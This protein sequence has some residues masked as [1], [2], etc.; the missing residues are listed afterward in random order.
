MKR[1]RE[2]EEAASADPVEKFQESKPPHAEQGSSNQHQTT[3]PAASSEKESVKEER[4]KKK[5]RHRKKLE[6]TTNDIK[7]G[8]EPS[9]KEK[10][11][12]KFAHEKEKRRLR[13]IAKVQHNKIC[14]KCRKKG[15]EV[16]N[17][18]SVQSGSEAGICFRCGSDQHPLNAC[19]KPN[20]P[21]NPYPFATCYVCKETGHI[22]AQCPSNAKGVYVKGGGCRYCASVRHRAKDCDAK[23]KNKGGLPEEENVAVVEEG[24]GGDDL[25]DDPVYT[26]PAAQKSKE[27]K[28]P[29]KR[30]VKF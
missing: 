12:N 28:K 22:S 30:T 15:H 2:G 14:F 9:K 5:L 16:A 7:Q 8:N 17:C 26:A 13:R 24:Q 23:K 18:P 29:R 27:D 3:H 21:Q 19:P 1:P 6:S 25:G 10:R 4:P 20:N 11:A